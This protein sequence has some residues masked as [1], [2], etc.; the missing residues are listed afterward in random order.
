MKC[1]RA[2]VVREIRLYGEMHRFIPV[3]AAARGFHVGEM[4]VNH[5]P[6]KFGH[7]K[8]G[9]RR[10]V[11]GFLDLLTVKFLSDFGRRPQHVLGTFSL[12]CFFV[13]LLGLL[14]LGVSAVWQLF[15]AASAP[16]A[17]QPLLIASVTALIVGR[18]ALLTGLLA[19]R[20]AAADEARENGFAVGARTHSLPAALARP[21]EHRNG[22]FAAG[23][24]ARPLPPA[25]PPTVNSAR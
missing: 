16:A 3:L 17:G 9:V 5:R 21:D 4:E 12:A 15:D 2:E 18:Q 24:E 7:S 1:Y 11:K 25:T 23:G 19:E 14:Y 22:R 10:L 6:R 20:M 8:Y 13:A